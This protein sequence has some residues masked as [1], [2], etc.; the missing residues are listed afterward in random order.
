MMETGNVGGADP[1][2]VNQELLEEKE[3]LE[4]NI[5]KLNMELKDKN[6]KL[7]E[8]LDEMEEIKI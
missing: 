4:D 8:M 6:E 3:R 1:S 7:L 2:Q 5:I